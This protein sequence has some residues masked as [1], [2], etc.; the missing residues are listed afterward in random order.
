MAIS[1][2]NLYPGIKLIDSPTQI[3]EL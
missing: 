3:V 1:E 2:T